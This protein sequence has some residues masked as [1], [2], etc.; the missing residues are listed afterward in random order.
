MR[1]VPLA[2]ASISA[3]ALA[4]CSSHLAQRSGPRFEVAFPDPTVLVKTNEPLEVREQLAKVQ[5]PPTT[6]HHDR[7]LELLRSQPRI[8]AP[9]LLLLVEAVALPNDRVTMISNGNRSRVYTPRGHGEFAKVADQLIAEATFKLKD[10]DRASFGELLART[11]SDATLARLADQLLRD[12]DDGSVTALQEILGGMA[13]SPAIEPFL[14]GYLAPQGRLDGE[15]GWDAVGMLSFD[16]DRTAL[17][18]ALATRQQP[19]AAVRLP[20]LV[21]SMSFDEGR[22]TVVQALAEKAAPVSPAIARDVV[23]KFSFDEGR[24]VACATLAKQGRLQLRMDELV[25]MARLFSFDEGRLACVRKLAPSLT[26]DDA[27]EASRDLLRTFSF[28][29][30]R[31]GALEA[32]LPKLQSASGPQRKNLLGTFSFAS[33]RETAA[34]LLMR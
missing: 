13:G 8:S 12:L 14:V 20:A 1:I 9:H 21:A 2:L 33:S 18:R 28:D 31:L 22:T 15:R 23:A 3:L 34:G 17:V 10:V 29:D 32:I 5:L 19:I 24:Q 26:D 25:A 4:G 30:G 27:G 6:A 11:H 16:D 7:L